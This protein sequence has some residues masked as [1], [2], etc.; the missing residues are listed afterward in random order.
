MAFTLAKTSLYFGLQ[1]GAAALEKSQN[2]TTQTIRNVL[3]TTSTLA[4]PIATFSSL[5]KDNR[6]ENLNKFFTAKSKCHSVKAA[7]IGV[8]ISIFLDYR[9]IF[10]G[11][12]GNKK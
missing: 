3:T 6:P 10:Y 4:A 8:A 7:S 11:L 5:T 1:A 2:T 9:Y 12:S